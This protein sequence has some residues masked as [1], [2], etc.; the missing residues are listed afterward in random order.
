MGIIL[1][2]SF[3]NS[4]ST[5]GG[6]VLGGIN[7]LFLYTHF[8]E[9]D[10]YALVI[11]L[12]S[13]ANLL[14]PFIAVS[15]QNIII[16]FFYSYKTKAERDSFLTFVSL[17]PLIIALPIGF[18]GAIFY[19]KISLYLSLKNPLIREYVFIIYLLSVAVSYFELFYAWGKVHFKSVLGNF[20]KEVFP[21]ISATVLLIV[22]VLGVIYERTF[23]Y[24]L[25][26]S[27]LI[28]TVFMLWYALKIY[29]PQWQF[30]LPRNIKNVVNYAFYVSAA[31]LSGSFLL[32]IDKFMIPQKQALMQ[33]AYYT[34]AVY[35]GSAISIPQRAVNQIIYP[36]VS[37]AISEGNKR[38]LKILHQ[39]SAVDLLL[40]SGG[41]FICIIS[42]LEDIYSFTGEGYRCATNVVL[43]ISI[44]KMLDA[45][46]GVSGAVITNSKYYKMLLPYSILMSLSVVVGNY[47]FIDLW[48]IQGA[49]FSTFLAIFIFNSI[50]ILYVYGKFAIHPFS[51]KLIKTIFIIAFLYGVFT[52]LKLGFAPIV[53]III[54]TTITIIGYGSILYCMNI[55]QRI[56]KMI[57]TRL[58]L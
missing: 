7:T 47:F 13:T 26:V 16:K 29:K 4:V 37:K 36:I 6:F 20:L 11:F 31:T 34:V 49:A 40:L 53:N 45:I 32:D 25:C 50:K 2:Q 15:T 35:I 21:R 3:Q 10:Y 19:E 1:R 43:L 48:G 23:I 9:K 5:Y 22:L 14:V 18:L 46:T 42:N 33:L 52:H 58:G 54:K 39:K 30:A 27:Y 55:S 51:A 44:S 56:N 8:L 12:L 38:R 57:R 24:L 28:R 41:I 17:L